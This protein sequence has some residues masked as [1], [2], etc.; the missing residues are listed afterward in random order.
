MAYNI[1]E[2]IEN[3]ILVECKGCG[4]LD[5][6]ENNKLQEYI[7]TTCKRNTETRENKL[8]QDINQFNT[9]R[10]RGAVTRLNTHYIGHISILDKYK[11]LDERIN[12]FYTVESVI[13]KDN[14]SKFNNSVYTTASK[15]EC[16]CKNCGSLN[17]LEIGNDDSVEFHY[18]YNC[19]VGMDTR[20]N[21]LVKAN[22]E[23]ISAASKIKQQVNS[24]PESKTHI[25]KDYNEKQIIKQRKQVKDNEKEK[26]IQIGLYKPT[27]SK[28]VE[29]T[30]EK[31]KELNNNLNIQGIE[32]DGPVYT[33][34]CSCSLCGSSISIPSSLKNKKVECEGCKKQY[35]DTNYR[36]IYKRDITNSVKNSLQVVKDHGQQVTVSCHYCKR[37]YTISKYDF[38][39]GSAYCKCNV[40]VYEDYCIKCDAFISVNM[41]QLMKLRQEELICPRCHEKSGIQLSQIKAEVVGT[42]SK[43]EVAKNFE[44]AIKDIKNSTLK[45]NDLVKSKNILYTDQNGNNYYN[46][47]CI[48]H[49]QNMILTDQEIDMF[50]HEQ[51]GDVRQTLLNINSLE[52]ITS[53]KLR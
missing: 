28:R 30:L 32:T 52:D 18:C 24:R 5:I 36:G 40:P 9:I 1:I 10:K 22:W 2:K 45:S 41:E 20:H 43:I 47:R 8:Q 49:N 7:G 27:Y 12:M 51:C 35:Y 17:L 29:S 31:I 50:N 25:K 3:K 13:C 37:Q 34:Q 53:I 48:K 26:A 23:K 44:M 6:V 4:R 38:L 19:G 16:T 39:S 33:V 11:F 15:V 21:S 42:D 14:Q 46:C